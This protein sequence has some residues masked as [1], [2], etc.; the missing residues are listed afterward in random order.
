MHNRNGHFPC[1]AMPWNV[2]YM[3]LSNRHIQQQQCLY[4]TTIVIEAWRCPTML[5]RLMTAEMKLKQFWNDTSLRQNQADNSRRLIPGRL[6]TSRPEPVENPRAR[7][8]FGDEL[9]VIHWISPFD[10]HSWKNLLTLLAKTLLHCLHFLF[11]FLGERCSH[12]VLAIFSM[13]CQYIQQGKC[14]IERARF[15]LVV[16]TKFYRWRVINKKYRFQESQR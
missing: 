15:S 14:V 9:S 3:E 16:S 10:L 11:E 1:P 13:S 2:L 6:T 7:E 4:V 8:T 12:Q 5:T